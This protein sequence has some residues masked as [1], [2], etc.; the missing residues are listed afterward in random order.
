MTISQYSVCEVVD[1]GTF[2]DV[3]LAK[4]SVGNNVAIKRLTKSRARKDLVLREV[5]AGRK[6]RFIDGIAP[7]HEHYEDD[8]HHFLVFDYVRGTNLFACME[9][10]GMQAF[11]ESDARNIFAQLARTVMHAHA[12]G[13]LHLDLK[14]ENVLLDQQMRVKLIDWG[15]CHFVQPEDEGNDVCTEY[16]GSMEY[17][18]PEILRRQPFSG[19]AA[20]AF[21]LGVILY[22]LLF[23][24]FP[25]SAH[26][27]VMAA[28]QKAPLGLTFPPNSSVSSPARDLVKRLLCESES[29]RISLLET[30]NHGWLAECKAPC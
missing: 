13:V 14:L 12:R 10:K 25:W 18:S 16:M 29:T 23:A 4:N 2:S 5:K 11:T 21:S 9:S 17:C 6:L 30:M 27:R 19:K 22:I 20:D 28:R 8:S 1:H 3:F 7:F 15:F 26:E 24:E